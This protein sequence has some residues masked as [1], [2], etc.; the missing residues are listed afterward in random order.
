MQAIEE[1][2]EKA[3]VAGEGALDHLQGQGLDQ[4]LRGLSPLTSVRDLKLS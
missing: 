3:G 4:R 1:R 2:K